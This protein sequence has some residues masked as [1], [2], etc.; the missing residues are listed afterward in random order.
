MSRDADKICK[1][2]QQE[3]KLLI[4]N[5]PNNPSGTVHNDLE[6]LEIIAKKELKSKL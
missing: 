5:S 4:F 1:N 6:A 2:L 3:E